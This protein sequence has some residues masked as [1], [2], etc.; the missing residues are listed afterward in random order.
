MTGGLSLD[1]RSVERNVKVDRLGHRLGAIMLGRL[2]FKAGE[3]PQV[4]AGGNR[5][6]GGTS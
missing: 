6:D 4:A 1:V 3:V 5:Y 2:L